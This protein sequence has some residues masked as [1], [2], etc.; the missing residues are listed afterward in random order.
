MTLNQKEFSRIENYHCFTKTSSTRCFRGRCEILHTLKF[1][2][3]T[4]IAHLSL[5]A[6]KNFTIFLKI[7][8]NNKLNKETRDH[9][10]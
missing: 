9:C 5:N 7:L 6:L 1:E 8:Y 2:K 4:R 3:F 10:L